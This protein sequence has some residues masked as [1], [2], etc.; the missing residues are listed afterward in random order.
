MYVINAP[1]AHVRPDGAARAYG[2][3][4]RGKRGLRPRRTREVARDVV[5][6]MDGQ[7]AARQCGAGG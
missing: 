2:K 6:G 1:C 4:P 5:R 3:Q 7:V